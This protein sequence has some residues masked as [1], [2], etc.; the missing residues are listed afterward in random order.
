MGM[1]RRE[2][3]SA[4]AV[5]AGSLVTGPLLGAASQSTARPAV[6]DMTVNNDDRRRARDL[7]VAPGEFEPGPNNGITDVDGV[8]VGQVTLIEGDDIRTGVTAV[9]PHD[10]N[11][12][13]DKVAGAVHVANGFG[14]L[15][16]STQ[17]VELG[18]IETPVVLT[19]TLSVA[20]GVDGA[21]Q[22]TMEQP[23]NG[24]VSSVNAVVG[25]TN[26]NALNDIRGQHVTT[27]H[28]RSAIENA[29][30]DTV[31]DAR[32]STR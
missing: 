6:A 17:V 32:K 31:E 11:L 13:Q 5:A 20:A 23:D 7:G 2:V 12:F 24:S 21:V 18:T 15:A 28:V 14:K 27:D 1:S 16:G 3:L 8:R 25:E 29:T 30:T 26:D 9:L 4:G 19:N 22:W 10:G